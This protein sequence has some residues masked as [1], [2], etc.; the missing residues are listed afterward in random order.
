MNMAKTTMENAFLRFQGESDAFLICGPA[1]PDGGLGLCF[2]GNADQL[3]AI[4]KFINEQMQAQIKRKME[5]YE[6]Q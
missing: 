5:E 2:Q 3:L 4:L 1:E 6:G